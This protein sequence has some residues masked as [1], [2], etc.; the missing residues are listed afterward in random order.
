MSQILVT[1]MLSQLQISFSQNLYIRKGDDK[2]AFGALEESLHSLKTYLNS[3]LKDLEQKVKR[4][5]IQRFQNLQTQINNLKNCPKGWVKHSNSCYML[6][7]QKSTWE[8]AN[9]KCHELSAKLVEISTKPENIFVSNTIKNEDANGRAWL[10]GT[11]K[12]EE[13]T[14]VWNDSG[15]PL[16]FTNWYKGEP[17]DH[18][19]NEDCME[20]QSQNG[21]WN[22]MPCSFSLMFV[23][24][25]DI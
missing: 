12:T 19:G 24:E 8:Q 23:C 7:T 9:V 3:E 11:D 1:L 21:M 18:K 6:N 25:R 22:D 20:I 13:N 2:C 4:E 5:N 14:W 16:N 15:L 17:N 10:G